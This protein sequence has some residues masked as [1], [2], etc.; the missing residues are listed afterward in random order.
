MLIPG[1]GNTPTPHYVHV[2]LKAR[3]SHHPLRLNSHLHSPEDSAD[4]L[5][6]IIVIII[7]I[8]EIQNN[9]TSVTSQ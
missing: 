2:C 8:Y 3:G 1:G 5:M 7:Y 9:Q 6:N 4:D